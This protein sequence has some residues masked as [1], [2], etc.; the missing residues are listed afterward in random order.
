VALIR[1]VVSGNPSGLGF[2]YG[3][4]W[5]ASS[6]MWGLSVQTLSRAGITT[7]WRRVVFLSAVLPIA[8]FGSVVFVAAFLF[9]CGNALFDDSE[10]QIV[11]FW[12][13]LAA[14]AIL[15]GAFYWAASFVCVT[16]A[17]SQR[18]ECIQETNDTAELPVNAVERS[19]FG[20]R[21]A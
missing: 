15:V 4:A 2:A 14:D 18:D 21:E 10:R 13:W 9:G 5:V 11:S 8:Y 17:N 20:D 3:F 16:V 6:L 12:W 1:L 7:P 19:P